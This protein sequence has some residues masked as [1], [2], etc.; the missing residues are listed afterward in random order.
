MRFAIAMAMALIVLG[1]AYAQSDAAASTLAPAEQAA[2]SAASAG[3]FTFGAGIALGSDLLLSGPNGTPETWT[4][5]SF[6]PDL[7]F[8]KIGFGF[9]L[10]LHFM[11]YPNK[12]TAIKLY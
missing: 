2:G 3:G 5:L 9:D 6:Q 10:T 4:K 11:L 8:G 12:D 7:A 1:S